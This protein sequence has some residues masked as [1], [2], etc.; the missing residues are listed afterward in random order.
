MARYSQ[1]SSGFARLR[2]QQ[3]D[4]RS[5]LLVHTL[6][7]L[8]VF[9]VLCGWRL[10]T[11]LVVMNDDLRERITFWDESPSVIFHYLLA[12]PKL[13]WPREL[14]GPFHA[15]YIDLICYVGPVV[16]LLF[17]AS[18]LRGWRWWHTLAILCAWLAIGSVRWYQP[19][20]WLSYWPFF[21]SAHV[22]TRWRLM[23]LLGVALA[24]ASELATLAQFASG[25]CSRS[26]GPA[27]CWNRG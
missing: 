4:E 21:R 26:G 15:V 3:P 25:R 20:S 8:G 6:T 13:D 18:M 14:P 10:A 24:V 22:V 27:R 1:C 17:F 16:L 12:R 2:V 5:R 7:A 23:A 11:V 9:L 19:S